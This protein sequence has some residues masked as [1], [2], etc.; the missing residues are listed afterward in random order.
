M[1]YYNE[2]GDYYTYY[3]P[4]ETVVGEIEG[5]TS[6]F[7][8][9]KPFCD[10]YL[11]ARGTTNYCCPFCDSGQHE[12]KSPAFFA[13]QN[14]VAKGGYA[15]DNI[16]HFTC[17]AVSCPSDALPRRTIVEVA[18]QV[19]VRNPE[20][21]QE[22]KDSVEK[23][24][25]QPYLIDVYLKEWVDKGRRFVPRPLDEALRKTIAMKY[26]VHEYDTTYIRRRDGAV[27]ERIE[28]KEQGREKNFSPYFKKYGID[29]DNPDAPGMKYLTLRGISPETVK[30]FR[31][32][33]DPRWI[34]NGRVTEF[35]EAYNK[36]PKHK[37]EKKSIMFTG[38]KEK[39][40]KRGVGNP[41][42]VIP[43]CKKD[44]TIP[45]YSAR[46]TVA[47]EDKDR[48]RND[49]TLP[50]Y[51]YEEVMSKKPKVL[52]VVEGEFDVMSLHEVGQD[53]VAIKSKRMRTIVEALK[54]EPVKPAVVIALDNVPD[55]QKAA[56]ELRDL[57]KGAGIS[58]V[59]AKKLYEDC[60][61]A[62][63][64][65]VKNREHLRG[66][67]QSVRQLAERLVNDDER[68]SKRGLEK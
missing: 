3:K 48:Y 4:I 30:K 62:N 15:D 18:A 7:Q 12:H 10:D 63:E 16:N 60:K 37:L 27:Q 65:L 28:I 61:D 56:E 64:L 53:A 29:A 45:A 1:K 17:F 68:V 9:L 23:L 50:I 25:G 22:V 44:G 21:R 2:S 38:A 47:V 11:T 36:D 46:A 34:S 35:M 40:Q 24:G 59:W 6:V 33:F 55:T 42:I 31:L 39:L 58:C 66:R 41:A 51:N 26:R 19:A 52:F 57:L 13:Y 8:M 5:K 49:G 43:Y 67:A 54:K 14:S 32:G 20:F